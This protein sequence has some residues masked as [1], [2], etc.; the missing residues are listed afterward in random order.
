MLRG[1]R[2]SFKALSHP[3]L[4]RNE[5][6]EGDRKHGCE[7]RHDEKAAGN[8]EAGQIDGEAKAGE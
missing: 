4:L 2:L 1:L 8:G 7:R 3:A 6:M 5:G